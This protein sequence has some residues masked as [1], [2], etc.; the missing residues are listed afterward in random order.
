MIVILCK[1]LFLRSRLGSERVEYHWK[2][3]IMFSQIIDLKVFLNELF[4]VCETPKAEF[5]H[6][7]GVFCI[8]SCLLPPEVLGLAGQ[9]RILHL[10][11]QA[12]NL[13]GMLCAPT[14]LEKLISRQQM[15]YSKS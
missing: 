1:S 2:W 6:H 14:L 11:I 15:K 8:S 10:V 13:A 3:K 12:A 4:I 5:A 7:K 9:M